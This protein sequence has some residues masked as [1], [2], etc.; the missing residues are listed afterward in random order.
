VIA[1][2]EGGRAGAALE[3][4]ER[5]VQYKETHVPILELHE[6]LGRDP[7]DIYPHPDDVV[8]DEATGEVRP[9]LRDSASL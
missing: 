3:I 8:I 7:P 6:R 4:L 9:K 1:R 2:A 5:A